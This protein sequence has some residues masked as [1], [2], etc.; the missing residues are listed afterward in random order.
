VTAS[1]VHGYDAREGER[2]LD[3]AGALVD[4]L[5]D[6]TSYPR[7]S[8]VLEAGC[9]V[10]AQTVTLAKRSP[11]ARFL[12]VDLSAESIAEARA[13][14]EAAGLGNVELRQG[15]VLAGG[16]EAES[17]DHVFVCFLLEH[18]ARPADALRHLV[19][20]L[21]PGGSL[22]VIEGD[23]GSA[24]FH[25]ESAA[26]DEAIQCLVELQRRAGGDS[27]LGRRLYPLMVASGLEAVQVAPLMVYVDS[28]RPDLVERFTKRTF[29]AMVASVREQVV[30]EGLL[31][32]ERFD[33]G[34]RGLHRA[35]EADGVFCYT[36]FKGVGVKRVDV[37]G[38]PPTR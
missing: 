32:A 20:L 37:R 9:G 36:F 17:F 24:Y 7:G 26:A 1:Y 35:A 18:L 30:S 14:V 16:F 19:T 29:T 5:H 8:V 15:D 23:H 22:T 33:E 4:L 3:Q 13:R 25:P 27:L 38:D 11:A 34:I 2:L 10:G 6:G 12:S 21:H 28:S 31:T